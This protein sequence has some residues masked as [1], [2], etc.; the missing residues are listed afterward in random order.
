VAFIDFDRARVMRPSRAFIR[1]WL[2]ATPFTGGSSMPELLVDV[3][4]PVVRSVA[5]R[6]RARLEHSTAEFEGDPTSVALGMAWHL[7]AESDANAPGHR[8]AYYAW[9]FDGRHYLGER[10]WAF[11]WEALRGAVSFEGKRVLELGS[12]MAMT[13]AYALL[14][15]A[16]EVTAVDSD[17]LILDAAALLGVA[18]DLPIRTTRMSFASA[19][20]WESAL[21]DADLAIAMSILEWVPDRAR[22]ERFLGRFPEV[23]FEGHEG[24]GVERDRLTRIGF[25]E[26]VL[27]GFSERHRPLFVARR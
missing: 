19:V 10:P 27:A 24:V 21:P 7:A 11:R 17:E 14:H 20:E 2:G 25:R 22:F 15:G 12:N 9:T 1:D 6:V 16:S 3:A 18:L 5:R 13:S 23:V 26:V 4:T 8:L